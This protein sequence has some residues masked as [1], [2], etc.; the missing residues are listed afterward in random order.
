MPISP[1][2]NRDIVTIPPSA[3]PFLAASRRIGSLSTARQ[4]AALAIIGANP[5]CSIRH[6][7]LGMG[8]PR[9]SATRAVDCLEGLG[10][11]HRRQASG[12]RREVVLT[13]TDKGRDALEA[14]DTQPRAVAA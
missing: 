8:T 9:P 1:T 11:V 7:A 10:M 14:M 12:D 6:L 2:A 3:L 4:A 5:G 13:L